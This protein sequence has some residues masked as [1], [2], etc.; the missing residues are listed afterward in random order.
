MTIR[1]FAL[2]YPQLMNQALRLKLNR[3]EI[4]YL[5]KS[6]EFAAEIFDGLHRGQNVPFICHLVRVASI[7]LE[8]KL[9]IEVVVA[10]LLHA[11]YAV[12]CFKDLRHGWATLEHRAEVRD[13]FGDEV[14][15]LIYDY[16]KFSWYKKEC[17]EMRLNQLE[18]SDNHE[19][20][21]ILM[22]LA[23]ELE[24]YMDYGM[25]YRGVFPYQEKL[26][27]YGAQAIELARR[28]GREQLADE[29]NEAFESHFNVNLPSIV[30]TNQRMS[31]QLPTLKW[32]KKSYPERLRIRSKE[33][34]QKLIRVGNGKN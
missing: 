32:L 12:G 24:D 2:T 3:E 15:L 11:A 26:R 27:A 25:E 14:E 16:D 31:Y 6:Y 20:Q 18:T 23:N 10:G 21:L 30:L 7:L 29:L 17:V 9:P 13:R 33:F 4:I 1:N 22:R 28:L 8:E 34:I 5:R 19:K